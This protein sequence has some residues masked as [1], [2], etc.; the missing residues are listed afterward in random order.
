MPRTRHTPFCCCT[1]APSQGDE[2]EEEEDG[3]K[4]A[5][6]THSCCRSSAVATTEA[7]AALRMSCARLVNVFACG[8]MMS[9]AG[10]DVDVDVDRLR[11][12]ADDERPLQTRVA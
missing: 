2:E 6:D 8:S 4:K 1:P 7:E 3:A 9:S 11:Y 5:E 10:L 12:V